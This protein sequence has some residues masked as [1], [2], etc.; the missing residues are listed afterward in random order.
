MFRFS[1]P[2]STQIASQIEMAGQAQVCPRILAATEGLIAQLP[3]RFAHD[4]SRSRLGSGAEAFTAAREAFSSWAMFDLGWVRVANP[5]ARIAAG[6]IVAVEV[7]SLSLWTL[8]LSR[9]VEVIDSA[10]QFGFIYSTTELHVEYGE[11]RFLLQC[12]PDSGDVWYDVEAVSRPRSLLARLGS[13]IA[14]AFQ[15]R[16]ARESHRRMKD[17]VRRSVAG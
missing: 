1:R 17:G 5:R 15:H 7:Q 2:T 8:N 9:I 16:F 4:H 11:E 10:E 3:A 12:D 14:R 6:Q 13:P